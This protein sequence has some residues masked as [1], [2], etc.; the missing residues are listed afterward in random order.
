[1]SPKVLNLSDN[2]LYQNPIN[3]NKIIHSIP[4]TCYGW[5]K[6]YF[7]CKNITNLSQKANNHVC[8]FCYSKHD[9][10]F[11]EELKSYWTTNRSTQN[12]RRA[13]SSEL[14]PSNTSW[15]TI[16]STHTNITNGDPNTHIPT[17]IFHSANS[18]GSLSHSHLHTHSSDLQHFE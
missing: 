13:K 3:S 11:N 18:I 10:F 6:L 15:Q 16:S 2:F 4:S 9:F 14:Y 1:M 17:G 5:F 12:R 8:T 7:V